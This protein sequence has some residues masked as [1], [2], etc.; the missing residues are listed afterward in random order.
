MVFVYENIEMGLKRLLGR[1]MYMG[2]CN[3]LFVIGK[4]K[5]GSSKCTFR[6]K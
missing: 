5:L 3:N 2:D 6:E 4:K 1:G